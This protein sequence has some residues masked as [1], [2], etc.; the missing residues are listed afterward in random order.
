MLKLYAVLNAVNQ[1]PVFWNAVSPTLKLELK[2]AILTTKHDMFHIYTFT[3]TVTQPTP[4]ARA[5]LA[6]A[7]L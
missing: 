7:Y 5:R 1:N 4:L 2:C 6:R 3:C